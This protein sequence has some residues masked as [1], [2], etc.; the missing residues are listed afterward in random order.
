MTLLAILP[1]AI[2]RRWDALAIQQIH[3]ALAR[4]YERIEFLEREASDADY[5]HEQFLNLQ[6]QLAES[7]SGVVGITQSGNLVLLPVSPT[8]DPAVSLP[9]AAVPGGSAPVTDLDGTGAILDDEDLFER[10]AT[11]FLTAHETY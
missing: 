9:C 4:Q 11:R 3:E 5:W 2:R 8:K 7:Q 10:C 1:P 6:D